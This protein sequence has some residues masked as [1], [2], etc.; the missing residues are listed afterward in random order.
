M[1][2]CSALH[3]R[4]T[5]VEELAHFL[6]EPYPPKRTKQLSL[7]LLL[8][9]PGIPL[10]KGAE[11]HCDFIRRKLVEISRA[12]FADINAGST[13]PAKHQFV[14]SLAI[15]WICDSNKSGSDCCCADTIQRSLHRGGQ[16][17]VP[18]CSRNSRTTLSLCLPSRSAANS[19]SSPECSSSFRQTTSCQRDWSASSWSFP[20]V[21]R[22]PCA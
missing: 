8:V 20:D 17:S 2:R 13:R 22:E 3:Q 15:E 6:R 16:S 14:L 21:G 1:A 4:D 19:V 9:Q 11:H 5:A 10:A 7:E 12:A 18:T